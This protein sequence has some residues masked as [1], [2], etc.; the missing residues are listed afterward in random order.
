MDNQLQVTDVIR[1]IL[2]KQELKEK[3]KTNL[4]KERS[5]SRQP[6]IREIYLPK[7]KSLSRLKRTSSPILK[8]QS[9]LTNKESNRHQ[10]INKK[11][12]DENT[13]KETKQRSSS[14][15]RQIEINPKS[16]GCSENKKLP[17]LP[18]KD[19]QIKLRTGSQTN[20]VLANK[21]HFLK[22]SKHSEKKTHLPPLKTTE[23]TLSTEFMKVCISNFSIHLLTM[24]QILY[25]KIKKKKFENIRL[26]KKLS[27]HIR[28]RFRVSK[29]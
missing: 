26:N 18:H 29:K 6:D 23:S 9:K 11:T 3:L 25:F 17:K 7:S 28:C 13:Q 14:I 8:P 1:E 16:S 24:F 15:S 22:N 27:F 2:Q 12:C 10:I 21:Q 20:F 4:S 5:R 19:S